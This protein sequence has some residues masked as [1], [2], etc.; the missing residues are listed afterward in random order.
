M[1]RRRPKFLEFDIDLD[2]A[3]VRN[4]IE[5]YADRYVR[6]QSDHYDLDDYAEQVALD[7]RLPTAK[8]LVKEQIRQME[9]TH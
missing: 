2:D 9:G 1:S 3:A 8:R 7:L 4:A 6:D 5:K